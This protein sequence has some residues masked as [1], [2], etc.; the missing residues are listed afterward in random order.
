MIH[1]QDRG[2][3]LVV[4]DLQ[5]TDGRMPKP[6]LQRG[7]RRPPIGRAGPFPSIRP[8]HGLPPLR[9]RDTRVEPPVD[10]FADPP[11]SDTVEIRPPPAKPVELRAGGS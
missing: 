6:T 5:A 2:I 4:F 7:S 3:F 10:D 8:H 9:H 11:W 1:A